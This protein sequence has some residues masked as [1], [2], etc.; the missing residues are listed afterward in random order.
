[1]W[2]VVAIQCSLILGAF[3]VPPEHLGD[4]IQQYGRFLTPEG[5]YGEAIFAFKKPDKS[6]VPR[7]TL[8]DITFWIMTADE[9]SPAKHYA[10]AW[11][12]TIESNLAYHRTLNFSDWDKF[13]QAAIAVQIKR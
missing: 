6:S 11:D 10:K 3:N 12:I 13:V 9:Q 5:R 2:T 8:H 4:A 7:V 1:V